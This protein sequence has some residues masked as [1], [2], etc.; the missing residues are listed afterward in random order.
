MKPIELIEDGKRL[1]VKFGFSR[2]LINEIKNMQG[3]HWHGYDDE[4]PKKMWS[5]ANCE[6]NW[7]QLRRMACE[8]VYER[9]DRE[10][11]PFE[12]TYPARSHQS[13]MVSRALTSKHVVWAAEMGVGKSLAAIITA[14]LSCVGPWWWVAPKSALISVQLEL[15]KWKPKIHFDLMTYE[16]MT[17]RHKNWDKNPCCPRGLIL[18]ECHKVKTP[19]SQRSEAARFFAELMRET[20]GVENSFTVLMSGTTAPKAPTDWWNLCEIACPG[21]LKEGDVG[22]FKHRLA[23]IENQQSLQGGV[24]PKLIGWKDDPKKCAV[25]LRYADDPIHG[26]HAF[27]PCDDEISKLYRRMKGLVTVKLKKDCLELPEK[28]YRII[29]CKPLPDVLRTADIIKRTSS[30]AIQAL[31][32]MRELSDGFQYTV[33][34]TDELITCRVCHGTGQEDIYFDP[35]NP[36]ATFTEN[37]EKPLESRKEVCSMCGG[38]GKIPKEGRDVQRVN[39]PKDDVV[40]DVLEEHEEIGRLVIF[41]SFSASVDRCVDLCIQQGWD[42]IR[43]DAHGMQYIVSEYNTGTNIDLSKTECITRF[44]NPKEWDKN[45][46]YV[47]HPASGGTGLT[48]TASPSILYFSNSFNGEDRMQS[49]DRIHRLGM[50]ENRGATIIDIIHLPTDRL[51][52]DNLKKKKKLQ[53]ATLGEIT[54]YM[55]KTNE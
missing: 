52:L 47:G 8:N 1:W 24:F 35:D 43:M 31:T 12:T 10:P 19:T 15:M 33:K 48:L 5:I 41:A 25:C 4:N 42:V 44:Q 29:E 36:D 27:Q 26:E 32:F 54:E 55:E 46:A 40:R 37:I 22:R 34:E 20:F 14:E 39:C 21:F 23:V 6:R 45:I 3:S 11:Q 9:Y 53:S 50:D 7:F 51:I 28:I 18:D 17:R 2:T 30:R 38:E 13:E 16:E 49:E